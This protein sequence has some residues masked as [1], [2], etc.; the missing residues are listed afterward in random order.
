MSR[1]KYEVNMNRKF[2]R[3]A[4]R[5]LP[6]MLLS[7]AR[8]VQQCANIPMLLKPLDVALRIDNI[9]SEILACSF[10]VHANVAHQQT[11]FH[12]AF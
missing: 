12:L 1:V 6:V 2:H 9:D 4:P 11:A 3:L 8:Y 7:T 5:Q 10:E